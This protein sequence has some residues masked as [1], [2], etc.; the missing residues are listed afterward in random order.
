MA[1][2][3]YIKIGSNPK[4]LLILILISLF[5]A[6]NKQIATENKNLLNNAAKTILTN[7]QQTLNSLEKVEIGVLSQSEYAHYILLKIWASDVLGKNIELLDSIAIKACDYFIDKRDA[8]NTT[9]AYFILGRI[10]ETKERMIQAQHSYMQADEWAARANYSITNFLYSSIP[11]NIASLLYL[12]KQYEESLLYLDKSLQYID[13]E[14]S[15]NTPKYKTYALELKGINYRNL[16]E[17]ETSLTYYN[18]ALEIAK[19]NNDIVSQNRILYNITASVYDMKN[20]MLVEKY[21]KQI[22]GSMA[23][24]AKNKRD[25]IAEGLVNITLATIY[26]KTNRLDSALLLAQKSK[27]MLANAPYDMQLSTYNLL[28]TIEQKK[29]N[30]AKEA[31]YRK[32]YNE[33]K[34]LQDQNRK[35]QQND[36]QEDLKRELALTIKKS[37]EINDNHRTSLRREIRNTNIACALMGLC[38]ALIIFFIRKA[39]LVRQERKE[40]GNLA[41]YIKDELIRS[42]LQRTDLL[43][44]LE[45]IDQY[46]HKNK[47]FT[48]EAMNELTEKIEKMFPRAYWTDESLFLRIHRGVFQKLRAKLPM[49]DENEYWACCLLC[50]KTFSNEEIAQAL[51]VNNNELDS[52]ITSIETKLEVAGYRLKD[53]ERYT[54]KLYTN[55]KYWK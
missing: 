6:C 19:N 12:D 14:N 13:K 36:L 20:Y 28:S 34:T 38:L 54:Q 52:I 21:C 49:L 1:L 32:Q 24:M 40:F 26:N 5:T 4:Y 3:N 11:Y 9:I 23:T 17:I 55:H 30:T 50:L 48:P 15:P 42:R 45:F 29:G 31:I 53:I 33:L 25:T 35:L 16:G 22:L 27:T 39:I 41:K 7:P 37:F 46:T 47:P 8:E 43:L 2:L 18:E 10:Y 51:R 44:L